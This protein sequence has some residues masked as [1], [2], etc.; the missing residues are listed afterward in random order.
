M[1]FSP[2]Q[3]KHYRPLVAEA[4]AAHCKTAQLPVEP[5]DAKKP[6]HRHWYEEELQVATGETSTKDCD[7]KRD[8][9]DAMEH[10]ERLTGIGIYWAVRKYGADSR[11]ILYN[12]REVCAE[13]E[14]DENY[15]R[16]MARNCL[17]LPTTDPLP[18]LEL[19][20]YDELRII[21]GE[22]IRFIRRGGRP[23]VHQEHPF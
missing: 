11:R 2:G 21:M 4:W 10:F 12:L 23:R 7:K 15:M 17:R 16:G 14:I 22:L 5:F 3:Q 9:E 6:A 13:N 1:S 20:D 19:L 18:D 8:F